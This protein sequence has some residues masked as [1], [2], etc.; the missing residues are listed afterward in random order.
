VQTTAVKNYLKK[1]C[2]FR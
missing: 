1:H 2:D